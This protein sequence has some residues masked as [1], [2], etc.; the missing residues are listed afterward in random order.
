MDIMKEIEEHINNNAVVIFMKGTPEQPRCG[1]SAIAVKALIACG[2]NFFSVDILA[3]PEIRSA[4]PDYGNWPSFP[5]VWANGE[6][7]GGGDIVSE[8]NKNGELKV[9]ISAAVK[10]DAAKQAIPDNV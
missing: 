1:F 7:I 3:N 9:I 5:Q 10:S 2:E 8:L 6:L 4:L